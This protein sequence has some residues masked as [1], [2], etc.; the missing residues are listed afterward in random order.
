MLQ[1]KSEIVPQITVAETADYGAVVCHAM[2]PMKTGEA[3]LWVGP[4]TDETLHQL[5]HDGPRPA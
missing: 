1:T 4:V 2:A 5:G 3:E